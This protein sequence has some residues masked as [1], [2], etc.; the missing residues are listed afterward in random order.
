MT[1]A[2]HSSSLKDGDATIY[3]GEA[4]GFILTLPDARTAYFAGDTTVFSDMA[5]YAEIYQP[6]IAFLPIGDHFTMGP[7]EAA[8]SA[9]MLKV[10]KVIPMHF[11]TFPA[12]TGTPEA[13]A[14]KLDKAGIEV[15]TLEK[16][17][18]VTW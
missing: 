4:A 18:P 1:H 2:L 11:G 5:L 12:L 16:G 3:A 15:W 6:E 10:K 17:Q 13:L 7:H 8:H 9:R 14:A